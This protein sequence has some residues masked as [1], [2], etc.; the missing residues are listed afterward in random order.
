MFFVTMSPIALA[1]WDSSKPYSLENIK[2]VRQNDETLQFA[3]GLKIVK[4]LY[5]VEELWVFTNRFQVSDRPA[6]EKNLLLLA[7]LRQQKISAGTQSPHEVN[8]RIQ[9]RAVNELLD[10][11]TCKGQQLNSNFLFPSN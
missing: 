4:N 2:L 5:G 3:S 1:C 10:G 8:F 7:L 9:V 11:T 6:L